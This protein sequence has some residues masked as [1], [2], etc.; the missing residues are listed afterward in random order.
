M[1]TS[2]TSIDRIPTTDLAPS[3]LASAKVFSTRV[4][5]ARLVMKAV[6]MSYYPHLQ[7][8]EHREHSSGRS[9]LCFQ[10][11]IQLWLSNTLIL[12]ALRSV[13]PDAEDWWL[14]HNCIGTLAGFSSSM[15]GCCWQLVSSSHSCV[16]GARDSALCRL[17]KR[18][19]HKLT[20]HYLMQF[21]PP[22]LSPLLLFSS[23]FNH[24]YHIN[25]Q[26]PSQPFWVSTLSRP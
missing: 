4:L 10:S 7:L 16:G 13:A 1:L 26:D 11:T 6:I 3:A 15:S 24:V 12:P 19:G 18:Q 23:M 21:L 5:N 22:N 17:G 25:R 2:S 9:N 14:H 8:A 20:D